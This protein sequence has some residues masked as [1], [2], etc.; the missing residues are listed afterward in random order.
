MLTLNICA[1][2][3]KFSLTWLPR[4]SAIDCATSGT[5]RPALSFTGI[6][7]DFVKGGRRIPRLACD[8][9]GGGEVRLEIELQIRARTV[10]QAIEYDA[11]R[12][13][14]W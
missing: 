12:R 9:E 2:Q 8:E 1:Q 7:L 13:L 11:R 10:H 6:R 14:G 3:T 5:E 4:S